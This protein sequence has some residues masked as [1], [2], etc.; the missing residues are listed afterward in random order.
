M[1]SPSWSEHHFVVLD[2]EG[3]GGVP[4]E[5]V[6]ISTV[7]I[8]DGRL[9]AAR[10]WK[11]RPLSPVM[12]HATRVHGIT[13]EDLL[14]LPSFTHIASELLAELDSAIIVGHH[15]GVDLALLRRQLPDWRP[16]TSID[17]LRLAKHVYPEATSYTLGALHQHILGIDSPVR[18]RAKEDAYMTAQLFLTLVAKL[19]ERVHLDL[20]TLARIGSSLDDPILTAQQGSLF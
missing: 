20:L 12:P 7:H 9:N 1:P 14:D 5:I 3:N 6:E 18:H 17:T 15:V 19:S 10:D 11:V 8:Q 13:N 4:Q 16:G 2:V